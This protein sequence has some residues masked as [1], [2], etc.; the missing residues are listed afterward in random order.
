MKILV[1]ED[2][3]HLR[4]YITRGLKNAGYA[5]E[6]AADG[7]EG[8]WL[9]EDIYNDVIVLDLM[10]PKLDGINLLRR[11]RDQGNKTHVLI[12]S[13]KTAVD[14]RIHGLQQGADDYLTKP[15]ALE[16]LIARVQALIR[17]KYDVKTNELSI[18]DLSIDTVRRVAILQDTVL[19]LRPRE[20]ALLEYMAIR[21][22]QAISR[23]EIEG[24]VYDGKKEVF[25]NVV[26]SSICILRRKLDSPGQ[27]S[28]IKTLHRLGY[29]LN[30]P[31]HEN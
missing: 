4:R 23:A 31:S 11:L 9:A 19:D 12:L 30:D 7:E 17:R 20:Y 3:H 22:G 25:S 14:D 28:Y 27:F 24:H 5:V 6:T 16:E 26:D 8:I 13:A 15:F 2:A 21:K 10:L 18:G 29:V 1:I